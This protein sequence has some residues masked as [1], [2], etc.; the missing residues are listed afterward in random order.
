MAIDELACP[1]CGGDLRFIEQY[2]RHYCHDCGQYAP[3]G[4]GGGKGL[5]CPTCGGVLSYIPEY[6]RYY[7]HRDAK[8]VEDESVPAPSQ[9]PEVSVAPEA[10]EFDEF[11]AKLDS[12]PK[13]AEPSEEVFRPQT[14]AP[15][16]EPESQPPTSEAA[17]PL[18]PSA[19]VEPVTEPAP[20][21]AP[22]EPPPTSSGPTSPPTLTPAQPAEE[23]RTTRSAVAP[24][25]P[26]PATEE[27]T[28]PKSERVLAA[29]PRPSREPPTGHPPLS[30][31]SLWKAKKSVLEQLCTANGVS[32]K[33]SRE[34]LRDRLMKRL[35][36]LEREDARA[37]KESVHPPPQPV[38][39]EPEFEQPT[40]PTLP[41]SPEPTDLARPEPAGA[42]DAT[43]PE[44]R[45]GT[46]KA[47]PPVATSDATVLVPRPVEA[48]KPPPEGPMATRAEPSIETTLGTVEPHVVAIQ[49]TRPEAPVLA[50]T[51]VAH[52]PGE[53]APAA[54]EPAAIVEQPRRAGMAR[55]EAPPASAAAPRAAPFGVISPEPPRVEPAPTVA[56]P[57]AEPI[58]V[59]PE[60][61]KP[62]VPTA[63]P[64]ATL[65]SPAVPAVPACPTCGRALAF[66]ADFSRHYCYACKKYVPISGGAARTAPEARVEVGKAA[67]NLCPSCGGGLRYIAQYDRYYCDACGKYAARRARR[68]CP[69]CG[70]DLSW[71]GR[72]RRYYCTS[73][74]RYA[75][76]TFPPPVAAAAVA[77]PAA[78]AGASRAPTAAAEAV[79]TVRPESAHRHVSATVPL[80]IAMVGFV[81]YA[82]SASLLLFS[83]QLGLPSFVIP[84]P[85]VSY[86]IGFFGVLLTMAGTIWGLWALNSRK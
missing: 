75:P 67:L 77:A 39:P 83:A 47:G 11:L 3:E 4:F 44:A 38:T 65:P 43:F 72:Y 73:C 10:D 18:E 63:P 85:S 61:A 58:V 79:P 36:E 13:P 26:A 41:P 33:G 25:S 62:S 78:A 8:Y 7:C 15:P 1:H 70:A 22:L 49:E 27:P 40:E 64:A 52:S 30:R 24:P 5:T 12:L 21:P 57:P 66:I 9:A 28:P 34:T 68:P 32:T 46:V 31:A 37:E 55:P 14:E 80:G 19:Q 42:G 16:M 17:P 53:R 74:L 59:A 51:D 71:V 81:L 82:L 50:V 86:L 54:L 23:S 76:A 29:P 20:R 56:P 2:G 84:T 60:A 45:T 69:T 6:D 35:A 48:E